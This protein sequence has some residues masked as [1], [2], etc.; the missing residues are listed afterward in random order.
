MNVIIRRAKIEDLFKI[1]ELNKKLFE[2]EKELFDPDLNVREVCNSDINDY[3][4][5]MIE[6]KIVFLAIVDNEIIGYLTGSIESDNYDKSIFARLKNIFILENY[7][8]YGI[9]SKLIN[10]FK[11]HCLEK[12]ANNLKV[13][14]YAKNKKATLFYIKNGFEEW[15]ITLKCKM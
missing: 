12:N 10:E 2:L 5:D 14:T 15:D 9:G 1:K 6:N 7:R 13:T 4:I 11:K 8:K 3:L